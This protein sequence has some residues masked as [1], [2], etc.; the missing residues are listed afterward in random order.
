MLLRTK[1]DSFFYSFELV[2]YFEM[3]SVK[4]PCWPNCRKVRGIVLGGGPIVL[5]GLGQRA[6]S[7]RKM[8]VGATFY[9]YTV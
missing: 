2:H 3:I 7:S 4:I 1:A 9:M 6:H 8:Q 5:Q